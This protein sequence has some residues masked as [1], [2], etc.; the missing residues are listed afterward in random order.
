M[1]WKEIFDAK[2]RIFKAGFISG[3]V[4]W[5]TLL[6][7]GTSLPHSL[8]GG[9]IYYVLKFIATLALAIAT[10]IGTVWGTDFYKWA[11]PK[12]KGIFRKRKKPPPQYGEN[13]S[14]N[15]FDNNKKS[16]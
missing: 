7:G 3:L 13:F 15:G 9:I 2:F 16:A 5:G 11:K 6:F 14:Q 8:A 4:A 1:A 10:A 12:A